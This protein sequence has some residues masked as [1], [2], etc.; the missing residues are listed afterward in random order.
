LS[1]ASTAI[2]PDDG[3]VP[4]HAQY[5]DAVHPLV[6]HDPTTQDPCAQAE[7]AVLPPARRLAAALLSAAERAIVVAAGTLNQ[8]EFASDAAHVPV[9]HDVQPLRM[10][11]SREHRGGASGL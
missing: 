1:F 2:V 6:L 9:A 8:Q 11:C 5:E 4:K 3:F 7:Q 10:V